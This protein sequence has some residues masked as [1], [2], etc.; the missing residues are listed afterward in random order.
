MLL[1][2]ILFMHPEGKKHVLIEDFFKT[3]FM[4][5]LFKFESLKKLIECQC[6]STAQ[7]TL[8]KTNSYCRLTACTYNKLQWG[9]IPKKSGCLFYFFIPSVVFM[10]YLGYTSFP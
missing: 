1:V 4:E 3:F 8:C 9:L 7:K 10:F 2:V 5:I 6:R